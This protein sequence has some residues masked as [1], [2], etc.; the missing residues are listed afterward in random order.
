MSQSQTM[1]ADAVCPY[2]PGV[3]ERKSAAAAAASEARVRKLADGGIRIESFSLARKILR[4]GGTRQAGFMAELVNRASAKGSQPVLFQ[5]GEVHQKQRIATAKFFAPRVVTSRYRE[6]MN[7]L[8]DRLMDK[9]KKNGKADLSD[10]SLDMAVAVAAEIIGLT[11]GSLVG[12]SNRLNSFFSR[13]LSHKM[14]RF[15]R[16]RAFISNQVNLLGF[17]WL[18]VKPAIRSRKKARKE[19]V[20]SHLIDQGYSDAE[21]LTECMTYGAAGMVTTRE[22]IVMSAWHLME[23]PELQARFVD[24]DEPGRIAILEEILRLEPIVGA[25]YRRAVKDLSFEDENGKTVTIPAGTLIDL[26][27]RAAN[28]DPIAAGE[29]PFQLKPDRG[30]KALLGSMS[31][32]DGNHRCPGAAVALQESAIFLEKLLKIPGLRFEKPPTMEWNT[33]TVGYELRDAII[34]VG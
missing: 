14:N 34:A 33:L 29:C 16:A 30:A 23:R 12:M 5:E 17:F 13:G 1:T 20:I 9:L 27:I 3:D 24:T 4:G 10:L 22:F 11:D 19:D 32:G 21:I 25:L 2:Q 18:D 6:L 15:Q 28:A 26:D 8:G 7:T 31:F